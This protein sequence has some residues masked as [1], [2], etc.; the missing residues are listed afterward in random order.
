MY[1]FSLKFIYSFIQ[2]VIHVWLD[3]ELL[4]LSLINNEPNTDE[5]HHVSRPPPRL[6]QR[7]TPRPRIDPVKPRGSVRQRKRH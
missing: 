4:R 1:Y 5:T 3:C 7:S 6:V 2:L